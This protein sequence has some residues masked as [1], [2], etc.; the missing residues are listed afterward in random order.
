M[1]GSNYLIVL[2][3]DTEPPA[4]R[5]ANPSQRGLDDLHRDQVEIMNIESR[6][7]KLE[8]QYTPPMQLIS[9]AL[10]VELTYRE[11]FEGVAQW[12][13]CIQAGWPDGASE[14]V[15]QLNATPL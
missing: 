6:L 13:R 9:V 3:S 8:S 1:S 2:P 11:G 4:T 5:N 12:R 14:K 10:R 15:L 7:K